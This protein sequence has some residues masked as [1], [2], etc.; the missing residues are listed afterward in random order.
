MNRPTLTGLF[1]ALLALLLA[2]PAGAQ[3]PDGFDAP[4]LDPNADGT[5]DSDDG[6]VLYYGYALE[7]L[8]GDGSAGTGVS[9]FRSTLLGGRSGLATPPTPTC[10]RCFPPRTAG[11]ATGSRSEAT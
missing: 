11:A 9:R 1:A 3:T 2:A 10:G 5:L 8:L 6:L 4:Q 7:S